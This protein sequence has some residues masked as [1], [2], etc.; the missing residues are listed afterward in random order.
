MLHAPTKTRLAMFLY[1]T[2]TAA[3][4]Y[5][6]SEGESVPWQVKPDPVPEQFSIGPIACA[7]AR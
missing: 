6:A 3:P 7:L 5:A 1:L 2:L 4:A